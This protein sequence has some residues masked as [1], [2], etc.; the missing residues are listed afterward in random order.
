[1]TTFDLLHSKVQR[2]I[3]DLGWPSFRPIQDES[4]NHLLLTPS[5]VII[6]APTA[7]GKT[8]AAFLPIISK[9]AD[10]GKDSVKVLYV[11]PLKALINDQ[12]NRVTELCKKIAF[13]I[14]KWHGDANATQKA[15]LI[16]NP[17]GILLITPESIEALFVNKSS[18]MGNMFKN[19][20]YIVIDEV[21]SF[22]ENERGTHLRS[23]IRR[24][25]SNLEHKPIKIALSATINNFEGIKGWL[26]PENPESVKL[27]KDFDDSKS[28]RGIIKGFIKHV[29]E[30]EENVNEFENN[31]QTENKITE[32]KNLL[33]IQLFD[34]IKK[35]K[36]LIF[37][38]SKASLEYYCDSMQ[39][40]AKQNAYPNRFFIH[41]G[42]LSKN[43]RESAEH[44]LK[45]DNNIA[46]FCTNT[47]E[48][49]IDIGSI[50]RVVL[51]D[52]PFSVASMIQRL[53][54]SGRKENEAK[55]FQ[56]FIEENKIDDKSRWST[57]FR[58][59]LVQSIAIVEL[60]IE[61]WCEPLATDIF[62]Y[63]T[64]VHQIFSYLGQTGGASAFDIYKEI[65]QIAFNKHFSQEDFIEILKSLKEKELIYQN[66]SNLITLDK[67][68][69]KIVENYE[70]YAAFQT[71]SEWKVIYNGKEIGQITSENL[72]F[73]KEGSHILL[74]GKR[75]EVIEIKSK[76]EMILVKKAIGKK[77]VKFD[78]G[79]GNIHKKIHQKML[80]IYEQKLIPKYV[81][82]SAISMLEEAFE[83]YD[84][85][86]KP[87]DS[88]I[89][90]VLEGTKTQQTI[91][92]LFIY[93]GIETDWAGIGFYATE[94]KNYLKEKLKS[95]NFSD[96]TPIDLV[97]NIPRELKLLK[98]YDN[99]LPEEI[100]NKSYVNLMLDIKKAR[101][102]CEKL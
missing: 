31:N 98:K 29:E 43:I 96:L 28:I 71:P 80:E 87:E 42:S 25:E 76:S 91:L 69:E 33:E 97:K 26:N 22:I 21:H 10:N 53:G 52:P 47:L 82:I 94:G 67:K 83:Q 57:R 7:S 32:S 72:L 73:I 56:F 46:V 84:T 49:G 36:N 6:S 45:N 38:N 27:I 12:F 88:L 14:T 64:F 102:F 61:K 60:M 81:H 35:D 3:W 40:I 74:A 34:L 62:D 4:I 1:M 41:H 85:Y 2:A 55:E 100:L 89:L 70:F 20:E 68:G 16:K 63:S 8:E 54:R 79:F 75:W 86:V 30:I 95:I 50:T 93:L 59:N 78:S 13:P 99:F 37:A 11:S 90:P 51:L 77:Q 15:R 17:S 65:G 19:L 18:Q 48:L 9:I 24:L 23:L 101:D 44:D 92:L 58:T 5:D 66:Q 39:E